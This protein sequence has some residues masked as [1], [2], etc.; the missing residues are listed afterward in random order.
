MS[1]KEAVRLAHHII[2][3]HFGPLVA[4]S[5]LLALFVLL[6]SRSK[7]T[8]RL[9]FLFPLCSK[10]PTPSFT[11]VDSTFQLYANSLNSPLVLS[12]LR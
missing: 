3:S 12:E 1:D 10:S 2:E 9:S 5:S 7:L 4:V 8:S 6:L 11:E